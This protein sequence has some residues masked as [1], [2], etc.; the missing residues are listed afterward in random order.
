MA[1]DT[2][3]LE[4]KAVPGLEEDVMVPAVERNPFINLRS[5]CLFFLPP[6]PGRRNGKINQTVHSLPSSDLY[7][8]SYFNSKL[9]I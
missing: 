4:G 5:F 6:G 1:G 2:E 7:I 9:K 8:T 3:R